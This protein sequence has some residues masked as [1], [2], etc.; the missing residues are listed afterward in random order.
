MDKKERE[1]SLYELLWNVV[2]SWRRILLY[3]VIF[4]I[5]AGAV[6]M[7]GIGKRIRHSRKA[8]RL[9][10]LKLMNLQRRIGRN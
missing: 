9:K 1:V 10:N 7:R 5:L 3:A 6:G 4:A 8:V 2:F